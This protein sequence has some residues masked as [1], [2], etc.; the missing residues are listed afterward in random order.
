[1]LDGLVWF[2]IFASQRDGELVAVGAA[3]LALAVVLAMLGLVAPL[4]VAVILAVIAALVGSTALVHR[5]GEPA[6]LAFVAIAFVAPAGAAG[7]L[8]KAWSRDRR[9]HL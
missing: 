2:A 5:S 6:A 1:V 4:L 9:R 3:I 8:A 7:L